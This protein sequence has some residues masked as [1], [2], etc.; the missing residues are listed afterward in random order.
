MDKQKMLNAIDKIATGL[1]EAVAI[2]KEEDD[3][4]VLM[5]QPEP[6]PTTMDKP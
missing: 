5:G 1:A 6:A 3:I 4:P 2:L